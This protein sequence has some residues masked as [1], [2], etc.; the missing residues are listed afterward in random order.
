MIRVERKRLREYLTRGGR[1]LLSATDVSGFDSRRFLL[2]PGVFAFSLL[3]I[4]FALSFFSRFAIVL[5]LT[6]VSVLAILYAR[7]W[8]I[9]HRLSIRRIVPKSNLFHEND[10][11]E[12]VIEIRNRSEFEATGL[13]VSDEFRASKDHEVHHAP[14]ALGPRSLVRL[15]Y[16][17]LCDGGMGV[18]RLGPLRAKVVD[19]LGI[20]EFR[21][22]DESDVAI[23]V[24]PKVERIPEVPIRPS[25]EGLRYGNY[26]VAARGV[27]VNFSGVRP[28]A[29]GDS[30]RHVAWK[31]STRGQGLLVKE[32]EKVVGCDVNVVMNV[33]PHW[34]V[35]SSSSSTWEYAKDVALS[36]IQQMIGLGNSVAFFSEGAY[37]ESGVGPDHFHELSRRI[38]Q[39][40]LIADDG[41]EALEAESVLARYRELY[42]RGSNIFYITPFNTA[43]LQR[44]EPWLRRLRGEGFTVFVVFLD[45]N[46]FWSQFLESISPGLL[47]GAKLVQGIEAAAAR[48]ESNGI[49]TVLVQNKKPLQE[50]FRSL[51]KASR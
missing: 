2:S 20:F 27:S 15:R 51:Q 30:L 45:T 38:A 35:G 28:Y 42:P 16:E 29:F 18:H 1:E 26:E 47:L 36:L 31:L 23:E 50:S 14:E 21:V 41:L 34:Q 5:L 13:V 49:P 17:R 48:L 40:S 43:E 12:I 39:M 7:T 33:S 46:T 22:L 4:F 11:V 10:K 3:A 44:S 19:P 37:I 9:A 24:Y 32:F 8:L 25:V 6:E